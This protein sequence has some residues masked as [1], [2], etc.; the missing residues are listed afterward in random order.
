M[1][2]RKFSL[3]TTL[4]AGMF[5]FAPVSAWSEN[6]HPPDAKQTRK[7]S[8]D[9]LKAIPGMLDEWMKNPRTTR[10]GER[11]IPGTARF[12]P[13]PG[14]IHKK[15]LSP[16]L[17]RQFEREFG[18]APLDLPV[19]EKPGERISKILSWLVC[20]GVGGFICKLIGKL[21]GNAASSRSAPPQ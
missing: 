2:H 6:P 8:E 1:R 9:Q 20:I 7:Q 13:Q 14:I 16:E 10:F 21:L 11:P 19:A 3:A 17:K 4:L 18:A 5:A 15:E 12:D